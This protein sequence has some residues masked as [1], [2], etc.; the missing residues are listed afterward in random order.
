[1]S[2]FFFIFFFV[3]ERRALFILLEYGQNCKTV[4]TVL[5]PSDFS[6]FCILDVS[7]STTRYSYRIS[8]ISARFEYIFDRFVFFDFVMGRKAFRRRSLF[9][10]Y[11]KLHFISTEKRLFYQRKRSQTKFQFHIFFY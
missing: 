3:K 5:Y 11:L 8:R 1:M 4:T 7:V 6:L 2:F 9:G 10:I